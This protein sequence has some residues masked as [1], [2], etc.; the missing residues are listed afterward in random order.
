MGSGTTPNVFN[1]LNF[2]VFEAE[3]LVAALAEL[4]ASLLET[5]NDSV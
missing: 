1:S 3:R 2:K 4:Y 5:C